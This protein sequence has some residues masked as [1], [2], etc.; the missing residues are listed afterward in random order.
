MK[1]LYVFITLIVFSS[2]GL[3]MSF[4]SGKE[5][6]IFSS[7]TGV[8]TFN[9]KPA[10]GVEINRHVIWNNTEFKDYTLSDHQGAFSF[11][12]VT[13]NITSILPKE[14]VSYQNI[15]ATYDGKDFLMWETVKGTEVEN[16]EL[17]GS[18][19]NFT[20]ELTDETRFVH[21]QMNSIET[22]CN[23]K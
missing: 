13:K 16:G 18:D 8:I 19:L 11:E 7:V 4:F 23:W 1:Y 17:E 6:F 14:F 2:V 15:T 22:M 5:V 3:A 20:C 12:A 9:D 10:S 21:L